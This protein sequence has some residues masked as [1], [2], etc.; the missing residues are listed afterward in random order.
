MAIVDYVVFEQVDAEGAP[1][2]PNIIIVNETPDEGEGAADYSAAVAEL[3]ERGEAEAI[4]WR[5]DLDWDT[6]AVEVGKVTT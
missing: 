5:G 1:L 3:Q 4:V 2:D 6:G